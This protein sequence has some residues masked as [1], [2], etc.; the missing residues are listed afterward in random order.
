MEL[1]EQQAAASLCIANYRSTVNKLL[2]AQS[3][4]RSLLVAFLLLI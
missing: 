3:Y 2:A 1:N 4:Q